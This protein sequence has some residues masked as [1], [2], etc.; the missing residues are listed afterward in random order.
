MSKL[1][2][3]A[4]DTIA[5]CE[6]GHY[7]APSGRAIDL[8]AALDAAIG[9]TQL[10]TPERLAWLSTPPKG[11]RPTIE[12]T[13]ETT[14]LAAHRLAAS[15]D[16]VLLNFASGRNPGG[17]FLR[18]AKAQEEDLARCSALYPCLLTQRPYYDA[19]R[20]E[21]SVLYTD[22]LI[23]SPRVPFFRIHSRHAPLEEPFVASVITA[24]A[25]NAGQALRRNPSSRP[26]IRE[27]LMGRARH[28]VRVA[29]DRGHRTLLLGAW[30]CGVFQNDPSEVAEAFALALALVDVD[31]V[32]FAIPR[33]VERNHEA[34]ARRFA[35]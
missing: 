3:V 24:P 6:R 27:A 2:Q 18:G 11:K 7:T 16:V 31:R 28:V 34:F 21:E 19:N 32:V 15:G 35:R 5:I 17:G 29:A 1:E 20:A 26:A 4:R 13:D 23:H 10:Y 33:G 30:G 8:R 25:P 14:Q 9:G 12:V 22:H